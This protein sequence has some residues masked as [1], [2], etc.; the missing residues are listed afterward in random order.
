MDCDVSNF[1]C[2][3]LN[4][5]LHAVSRWRI[6]IASYWPV[7]I[8]RLL[9]VLSASRRRQ[10]FKKI[11]AVDALRSSL[12]QRWNAQYNGVVGWSVGLDVFAPV[13]ATISKRHLELSLLLMFNRKPKRPSSTTSGESER[14]FRYYHKCWIPRKRCDRHTV[15]GELEVVDLCGGLCYSTVDDDL[16]QPQKVILVLLYYLQC[17]QSLKSWPDSHK[18]PGFGIIVA[19]LTFNRLGVWSNACT[20]CE[21]KKR[22]AFGGFVESRLYT[23]MH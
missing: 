20:K 9:T 22:M 15:I 18:N 6:N 19:Y 10:I 2:C 14:S 11:V 21:M 23:V 5:G 17:I 4:V 16:Q 1:L 12:A 7:V 8:H 3:A 13:Q